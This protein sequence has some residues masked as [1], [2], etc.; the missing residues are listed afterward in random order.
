M[1]QI[2]CEY[3][4][5]SQKEYKTRYDWVGKG[6]PLG[7]VQVIKIWPYYHKLES[8]LENETH[9]ILWDFKILTDHLIAVRNQSLEI[10]LKS[11]D[12]ACCRMDFAVSTNFRV[13]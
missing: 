3:S 10:I 11:G 2:I 8:V 1:N 9:K 7:I 12:G 6:D 13:K 4:K 5:L